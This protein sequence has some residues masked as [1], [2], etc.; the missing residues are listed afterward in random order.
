M[1]QTDTNLIML[2]YSIQLD[3]DR[4]RFISK[5]NSARDAIT[6]FNEDQGRDLYMCDQDDEHRKGKLREYEKKIKE[7]KKGELKTIFFVGE[8]DSSSA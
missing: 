4:E 8:R 6:R 2:I 3:G 1:P 7:V 5:V